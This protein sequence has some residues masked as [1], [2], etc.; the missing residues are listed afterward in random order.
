MKMNHVKLLLIILGLAGIMSSCSED[1]DKTTFEEVIIGTWNTTDL[2]GPDADKVTFNSDGTGSATENSLFTAESNGIPTN[3]FTWSYDDTS[4][5]MN[6]KWQFSPIESLNVDYEIKAFDCE[7]VT[8]D[9]IFDI[10][11]SK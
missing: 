5:E 10:V 6:I 1:C 8:M 3:D 4:M 7:E 11:I 2:S 9:Y